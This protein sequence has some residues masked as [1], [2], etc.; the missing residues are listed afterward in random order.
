MPGSFSVWGPRHWVMDLAGV[1]QDTRQIVIT[2]Q[3]AA[4]YAA[5]LIPFKAG[6]PIIPGF[7]ELRPANAIPIVASLLFGPAA[8]WGAG[9]GNVIGDCFGT[10]GPASFFGFWGNFFFGYLPYL[11]W[12]HLGWLSSGNPP[13]VNSVKQGVEYTLI[14]VLAS[15]ACAGTIGWGVEALGLLP[16]VVLAPAIF[17]NNIVMGLLLGPPLLKFLYPRVQRWRLRFED[18]RSA[19]NHVQNSKKERLRREENAQFSYSSLME[20]KHQAVLECAHLSFQYAGAV[21]PT[22]ANLSFSVSPGELVMVLGRSGTGKS[23]LVNT[24]NGLI[25][26]FI[27][28]RY[29]GE[30]SVMGRPTVNDPVWA[31]AGRVGMVFQDFDAQLVAST[32]DGELRHPLEYRNPPLRAEEVARRIQD[33]LHRVGLRI[34]LDRD[35]VTLS[36]GQRQR[37]VLASVLAQAPSVLVLDEPGSDLDPAG[38]EQLRAVLLQVKEEGLALLVTE[39]EY[40]NI[41]YADRLLV[42]GEE[43]VAW[44]G[45]PEELLRQP[46]LMRELGLRPLAITECFEGQKCEPIPISVAEAWEVADALHVGLH[47]PASVITDELRLGTSHCTTH[48][49]SPP[50]IQ[51]EAMS[52]GYDGQE[53]LHDLSFSIRSGEFLAIVGANGSGKS[54]LSRLLNGLLVPT[55]GRI[56]VAGLDTRRTAIK[57]L[58]GEVGLVFQNPD[59]QIFAETIWEEVAF[60]LRNFGYDEQDIELRVKEAL[61]SVGF[62]LEANWELDPFSLRKGERQRLAVAS[63]LA[64]RPRILIFDEPTTGLDAFETDRMM[65][66]IRGLNRDGHSVIMITHS[67]RLV[68]Q[69]ATYCILMKNGRIAGEG[70]PR[71]VFSHPEWLHDS[72]LT[73]PALSRFSQRWGYTLLTVE[74]VRA[75]FTTESLS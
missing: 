17:F 53:V 42:L 51:V 10:L 27:H 52:F 4:I 40:E 7:V 63:V 67:M 6:I 48:G 44:T 29:S 73:L 65:E 75:S 35:P 70:H 38:C 19:P 23:T 55:A 24:C 8:A 49:S 39:R 62:S 12:G 72:S 68:A 54:T 9:I 56:V 2:A 11:L 43:G 31:Q 1:W 64:S 61:A 22:L 15:A 32:A 33:A 5:I 21:A 71:E 28:G 69:Y 50:V 16:F 18:I 45:P 59:H 41:H 13:L 3:I 58:A 46:Q 60:G 26:H 74:E 14:C 57:E 30:M 36:G 37:L 34:G 25:P 20:R 66:M 47:P